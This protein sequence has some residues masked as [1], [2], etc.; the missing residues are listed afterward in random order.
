MNGQRV[1]IGSKR[2]DGAGRS[3]FDVGENSASAYVGA[4]RNT[5]R[6]IV[7][8]DKCGCFLFLKELPGADENG[9]SI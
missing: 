9:A 7:R 5:E 4:D 2:N 6:F 1:K 3:A 8:G